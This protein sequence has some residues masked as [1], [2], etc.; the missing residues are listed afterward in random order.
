[1]EA[2]CSDI[3]GSIE[4]DSTVP[5]RKRK[6]RWGARMQLVE[7]LSFCLWNNTS[8]N[9]FGSG[10]REGRPI[11][12]ML[13]GL[14]PGSSSLHSKVPLGNILNLKLTLMAVSTVC[15]WCVIESYVYGCLWLRV[16]DKT[17]KAVNRYS[18]FAIW[19]SGKTKL[20]EVRP[21]AGSRRSEHEFY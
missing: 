3:D 4:G 2:G 8:N 5:L 13:Y 12:S 20:N 1:M 21:C 17:E 19:I 11:T 15:E 7:V 14:I 16:V 6:C 18:P 9:G 10:G